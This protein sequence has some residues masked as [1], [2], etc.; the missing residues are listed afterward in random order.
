MKTGIIAAA[1]GAML[2][3]VLMRRAQYAKTHGAVEAEHV[4]TVRRP[5]DE[6]YALWLDRDQWWK[7]MRPVLDADIT[8]GENDEILFR[9][10][11]LTF[12]SVTFRELVSGRGTEVRVRVHRV[13]NALPV[14][15]LRDGYRG[16]EPTVHIKEDLR[17]F[18]QLAETGE[19]ATNEGPSARKPVTHEVGTT[20]KKVLNVARTM[21]NR[22]NARGVQ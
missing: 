9:A 6:L 1:S 19:I 16:L 20:A 4:V 3:A 21:K 22:T 17:R 15:V 13:P 18:K 8:E 2:G 11:K 12:G 5:V 7:W 14:T 10:E